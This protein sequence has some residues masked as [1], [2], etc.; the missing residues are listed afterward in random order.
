[1]HVVNE[2]ITSNISQKY[3]MFFLKYSLLGVGVS[4]GICLK[5]YFV[6]SRWAQQIHV[7]VFDN[8]LIQ[9]SVNLIM[10]Q[11]ETRE[12]VVE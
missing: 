1:M 11:I 4:V 5:I 12:T 9:V 8:T 10:T 6:F 2:P 3:Q 7:N